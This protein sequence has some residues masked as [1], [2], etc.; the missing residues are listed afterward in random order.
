MKGFKGKVFAMSA[1]APPARSL[2]V[3]GPR[4]NP[5]APEAVCPRTSHD[6]E[7]PFAITSSREPA[8][9]RA[10]THQRSRS[11]SRQLFLLAIRSVSLN[12]CPEMARQGSG[13]GRLG[14]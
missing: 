11:R 8:R 7:A 10:L 5:S 2:C 9:C 1:D 13:A 3:P 4:R 12:T 14:Q 6:C